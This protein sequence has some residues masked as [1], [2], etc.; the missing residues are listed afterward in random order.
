MHHIYLASLAPYFPK[1]ACWPLPTHI[2]TLLFIAHIFLLSYLVYILHIVYHKA[3]I[4]HRVTN[5][6][7]SVSAMLRDFVEY[8][9]LLFVLNFLD[10]G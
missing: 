8:V 1:D 6:V 4:P 3:W 10:K 5:R 7:T 2:I 9:F